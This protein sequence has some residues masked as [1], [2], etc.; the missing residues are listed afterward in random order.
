MFRR[1]SDA[2]WFQSV[3]VAVIIFNAIVLGLQTFPSIVA[4]HGALLNYLDMVCLAY[5]FVELIIRIGAFGSRPQDF[6]KSGWNV[7]DFVVVAAVFLPGVRENITLLR[8]ARLARVL[9]TIRIFPALRIILVAVGRSIPGALGLFAVA[10]VVLYFYGMLG[11]ILFADEFPEK[12]GNV[13]QAVLTLFF[14]LSL[15][16]LTNVVREAVAYSPWSLLF[17][18]SFVLFGALVLLNILVGVVINSMEEARELEAKEAAEATGGPPTL[19]AK[20]DALQ[21]LVN[22]LRVEALRTDAPGK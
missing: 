1:I 20:V 9:K 17:Y 19:L 5:F 6:F 15:D 11:W 14:L 7:F 21:E 22:E 12:Y 13:G 16:D 18:V 3:S 8:L 2:S 10:T 4:D